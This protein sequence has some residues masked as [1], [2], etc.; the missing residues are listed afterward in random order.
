MLDNNSKY[1]NM[2]VLVQMQRKKMNRKEL[3]KAMGVSY[4]FIINL[5]NNKSGSWTIDLLDK[6]AKALGI[7]D[8]FGLI[9]LADKER[10]FSVEKAA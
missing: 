3:A 10:S 1:V 7:E 5:L 9:A 8:S 6:A 2:A 4:T